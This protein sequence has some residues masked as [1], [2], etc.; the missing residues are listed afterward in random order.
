MVVLTYGVFPAPAVDP[1]LSSTSENN[2]SLILRANKTPVKL[3]P[4]TSTTKKG[5][6]MPTTPQQAMRLLSLGGA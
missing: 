3:R 1:D 4:F 6:R 2:N 5:N